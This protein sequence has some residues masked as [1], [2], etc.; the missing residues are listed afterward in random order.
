MLFIV[1]TKNLICWLKTR[2]RFFAPL[3][4]TMGFRIFQ[5]SQFFIRCTSCVTVALASP[6]TI[7]VFLS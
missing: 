2:V 1:T 4:M 7:I 6:K 3:R 5:K